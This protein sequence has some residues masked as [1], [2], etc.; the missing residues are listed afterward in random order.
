LSSIFNFFSQKGNVYHV[1]ICKKPN[2]TYPDFLNG[3]I[4]KHIFFVYYKV[5]KVPQKSIFPYQKALLT[6]ELEDFFTNSP[7]S[8]KQTSP[9]QH[10]ISAYKNSQGDS[11]ELDTLNYHS[12]R[13]IEK[14]VPCPICFEEM[15]EK[16]EKILFVKFVETT[17][18][19]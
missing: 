7:P 9:D 1:K 13:P 11:S 6:T 15:I 3:H 2:C 17:F 5:L 16:K 12:R 18:I 14:D 19:K 4:C 10:V 8:L